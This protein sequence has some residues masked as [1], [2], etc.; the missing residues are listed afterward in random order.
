MK[1]LDW[2][3][4]WAAT[5]TLI[6]GTAVNG[7][8]FYPLGP[9]I[10]AVGGFIWLAVAVMWR[11]PSLIVTNSIMSLTGVATLGYRLLT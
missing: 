1:K 9:I 8:G 6:V 5:A 10:L 7:L 3:L 2:Y 4:K 11:E